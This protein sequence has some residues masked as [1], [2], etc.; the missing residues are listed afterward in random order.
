MK[1][2]RAALTFDLYN[3]LYTV[4]SSDALSLDYLETLLLALRGCASKAQRAAGEK[5]PNPTAA[6]LMR[7]R[8]INYV[9]EAVASLDEDYM[10]DLFEIATEYA[11]IA[12]LQK[13]EREKHKEQATACSP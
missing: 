2:D 13:A 6:S 8:T 3:H 4:V 5:S 12:R 11:H 1:L 9:V 10:T 7:R